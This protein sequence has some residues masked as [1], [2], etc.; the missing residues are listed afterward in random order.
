MITNEQIAR[1]NELAHKKK[2]QGLTP[3]ETEE[4]AK[5]RAEYIKAFR[6]NLESQLKNIEIIDPDDPRIQRDGKSN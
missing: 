3:A 6:A 1:I 5:L 2:A 4:Q